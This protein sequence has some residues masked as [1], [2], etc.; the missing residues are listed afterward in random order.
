[1]KRASAVL[2]ISRH[3]WDLVVLPGPV[4]RP[5][6]FVAVTEAAPASF[7][8]QQ[9]SLRM[10]ECVGFVGVKVPA[11]VTGA[12]RRSFADCRDPMWKGAALSP[13]QQVAAAAAFGPARNSTFASKR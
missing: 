12:D 7:L 5:L 1:M 3:E 2:G 4:F 13:Q 6:V 8:P 10:M 9:S 11:Q